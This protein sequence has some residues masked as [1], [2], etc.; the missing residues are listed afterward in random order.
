[1]FKSQR[2]MVLISALVI[3]IIISIVAL[4]IGQSSL[5]NQQM[6]SSR[7]D[8]LQGQTQALSAMNRADA[9]FR[10]VIVNRV[11]KLKPGVPGSITT[12]MANYNWWLTDTNWNNTNTRSFSELHA[13]TGS[14][15]RYRIEYRER[16]S[17]NSNVEEK[18]IRQFY[19][20]T[21]RANGPGSAR[22]LL[23]AYF[24]FNTY[25]DPTK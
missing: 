17:V 7:S 9:E 3:L 14:D 6:S 15:P 25:E 22:S 24:I 10:D 11:S 5:R 16:I 4:A 21:S 23:Q 20:V 1:M 2:G 12:Q 8:Q 13:Q 19:R 18:Q